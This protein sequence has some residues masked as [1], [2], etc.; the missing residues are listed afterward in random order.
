[1]SRR[2]E[3]IRHLVAELDAH[4]AKVEADVATLKA[5][6]AEDDDE[7]SG[8]EGEASADPVRM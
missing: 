4:L 2:N 1:M 6:L 8:G 7:G 3:E 5:L